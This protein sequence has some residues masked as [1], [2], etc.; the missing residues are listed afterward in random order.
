MSWLYKRVTSRDEL[1]RK[2]PALACAA[3]VWQRNG[4]V[5]SAGLGG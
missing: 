4:V 3:V 1:S 5:A 2:G